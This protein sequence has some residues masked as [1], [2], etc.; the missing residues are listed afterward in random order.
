MQKYFTIIGVIKLWPPKISYATI[1]RRYCIGSSRVALIMKR[2]RELGKTLEELK[3]MDP[4]EIETVFYP[5]ENLKRTEKFCQSSS[6]SI[7]G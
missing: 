3:T 4:K 5:L 2:F 6:G 1:Q 7:T